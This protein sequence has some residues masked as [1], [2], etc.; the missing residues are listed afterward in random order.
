MKTY[1]A[2]L[3]AALM[4]SAAPSY[5]QPLPINPAVTQDT[6]NETICVHGYTRSIRPPVSYTNQ[7]KVRLMMAEG[8][9]LELI[10]DKILDHKISLSAGG[11][12]DDPRNLVLQDQD[13][14]RRKDALESKMHHMICAGEISLQEAQERLW[15]WRP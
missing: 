4:P 13:E 7:I 11:S 15:A 8:L 12:P 5:A 1:A 14:S 2:P 3:I 10:G 9:P 6:I